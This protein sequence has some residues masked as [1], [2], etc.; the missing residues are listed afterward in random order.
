MRAVVEADGFHGLLRG[1]TPATIRL[2]FSTPMSGMMTA[3]ASLAAV[4]L[5]PR[6]V[7]SGALSAFTTFVISSCASTLA[8]SL[9]PRCLW[10]A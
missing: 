8:S 5:V 3:P 6:P 10:S 4:A 1:L 9:Q 2:F 7:A